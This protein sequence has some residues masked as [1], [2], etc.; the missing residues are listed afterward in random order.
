MKENMN[1]IDPVQIC[2]WAKEAGQ[3]ALHYFNN[4]T[5]RRKA[6]RSLVSEADEVIEHMLVEQIQRTFPDHGIIGEEATQ[7]Q[8]AGEFVWVLDPID[9]TSSYLA[10]LPVWCI[11]IGVLRAGKPHIGVIYLPLLND[12]YWNEPDGEA[13]YNSKSITVIGER[14]WHRDDWLAIPSDAHRRYNINFSGKVR[15]TGSTAASIAYVARGKALGALTGAYSVWDVVGALA[16]LQAASGTATYLDGTLFQLENDTTIQ[17]IRRPILC[18]A[19]NH[20]ALLLQT[21]S[22]KPH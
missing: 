19:P 15:S 6:D 7:H 20:A 10:G 5:A 2:T 16:I 21:I 17:T 8:G 22:E 18:A 9:G 13:Y 12:L 1:Q 14:E 3:I 11:S 4:T